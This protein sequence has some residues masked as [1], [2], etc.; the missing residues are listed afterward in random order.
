[1]QLWKKH[2]LI[3]SII[4]R[5]DNDQFWFMLGEIDCRIHIYDKS[6]QYSISPFRFLARKTVTS[7]LEYLEYFYKNEPIFVMAVPPQGPVEDIFGYS[8]YAR[9]ELRQQI[10]HEFNLELAVQA[11][12]RG[13]GFVNLWEDSW[14]QVVN[15]KQNVWPNSCFKDDKAHLR[16]EIATKCLEKY[17]GRHNS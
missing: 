6:T 13:L 15:K 1:M 7:Y 8:N 17:V 3:R 10:A 11:Q 16:D 12:S 9:Q 4:P 14:K 5:V 2:F